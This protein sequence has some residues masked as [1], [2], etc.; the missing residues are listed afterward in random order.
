MDL[1]AL[2]LQHAG[3]GERRDVTAEL[4]HPPA[5]SAIGAAPGLG[6]AGWTRAGFDGDRCDVPRSWAHMTRNRRFATLD[7]KR[8]VKHA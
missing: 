7:G 1:L 6:A 3:R 4:A 5:A 2:R 8:C